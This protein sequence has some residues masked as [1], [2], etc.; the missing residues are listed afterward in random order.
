MRGTKSLGEFSC[1][2]KEF[3][4]EHGQRDLGSLVQRP[5]VGRSGWKSKSPGVVP[6]T[7]GSRVSPSP[8]W[9]T[10]DSPGGTESHK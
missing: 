3:A 10:Q 7:E 8:Q 9:M 4:T 2:L 6:S 5:G 1:E